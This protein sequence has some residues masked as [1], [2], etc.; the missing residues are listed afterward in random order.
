MLNIGIV[1]SRSRDSETEY[2]NFCTFMNKLLQKNCYSQNILFRFVSG[3]CT[4]GG[5]QFAERY[6][7]HFNIEI[8]IFYP[9]KSNMRN[10]SSGE[11]GRVCYER[12][13]LIAENSDELVALVGGKGTA[14]TVRTFEKLKNKK[15]ICI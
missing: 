10:N 1:G 6:A 15:A 12:N 5:D 4:R 9:D 11:Y 13:V 14:H 7:A 2:R 8:L 3:G